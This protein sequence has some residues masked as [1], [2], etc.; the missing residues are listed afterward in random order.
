MRNLSRTAVTALAM[1]LAMVGATAVTAEAAEPPGSPWAGARVPAGFAS[2]SELFTVQERMNAAADRIVKAARQDTGS[3]YAGIVADPTTRELR[4]YWKGQ[5]PADLSVT[6]RAA[7]PMRVL[8][9]AYSKKELKAAQA[10]LLARA[11]DQVT[12]VGPRADGAGLL[13][14]TAGAVF[15]AADYAGVPVTLETGVAPAVGTRANDAAPW[16]GGGR[17]INETLGG[18]CSTGFGIVHGGFTRVLSAGH[19]AEPLDLAGDPTGE[20]IGR[21]VRDEDATDV[22]VINGDSTGLVFVNTMDAQGR[23]VREFTSR[24]VGAR[25]SQVGN[26]VCTS[27]AASGSRCTIDVNAVDQCQVFRTPFDG[28]I[29]ICGLVRADQRNGTNA[30][31]QGDSGGPVVMFD[32]TDTSRAFATGTY[33]GGDDNRVVACTG[34]VTTNRTCW[35]RAWYVDINVGLD[36]VDAT[37]LTL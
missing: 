35:S 18:S 16:K 24:V 3:G 12:T 10:R 33:T 1:A 25:S 23:V 34:Y 13:V 31:G 11:G 37:L 6:A 8:P 29:E 26:V 15:P 21:V 5:P 22:L 30:G 2:W 19:C 17:W 32:G 36:A 7:V 4:V 14:G 20:N 9:A 28:N 27:G